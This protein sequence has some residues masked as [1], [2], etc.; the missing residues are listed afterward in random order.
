M[1]V[2]V[3][4]GMVR[5]GRHMSESSVF[6]FRRRRSQPRHGMAGRKFLFYRR[7]EGML[8]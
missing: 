1:S 6:S 2:L 3:S 4:V 5:P 8:L 7:K